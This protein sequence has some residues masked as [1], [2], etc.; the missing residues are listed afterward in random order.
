MRRFVIAAV[1]AFCLL[2]VAAASGATFLVTSTVD[3]TTTP[4]TPQ[5]RAS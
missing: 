3:S 1:L 2:P 5:A 4:C